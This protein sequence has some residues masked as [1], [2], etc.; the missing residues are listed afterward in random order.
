MAKILV[1]DDRQINRQFLVSLLK[2]GRH[3]LLEASDGEEALTIAREVKPDLIITD[4]LMPRMDGYELVRRLKSDQTLVNTP[5]IFYTAHYR[6][7]EAK[8]IAISCGVKHVITKPSEPEI[9]LKTV[10]EILNSPLSPSLASM[11]VAFEAGSMIVIA[12]KLLEKTTELKATGMKFASLIEFGMEMASN[13]NLVDLHKRFCHAAQDIIGVKHAAIGI[14]DKDGHTLT[15]VY[16]IGM[17]TE[18]AANFFFPQSNNRIFDMLLNK[19]KACRI[20]DLSGDPSAVGLPLEHP[21]VFSF[22]GVP[23]VAHTKVFGWL[24][25]SNKLGAEEFSEEDERLAGTLGA[26][27][28]LAY[29][30]ALLNDETQRRSA[31]LVN[32]IAER[33]RVEK[34]LRDSNERYRL[35]FESNP[36]PMWA[37]DRETLAFLTVNDSAVQR[38]GYSREEFLSMTIKDIRPPDDVNTLLASLPN[39]TTKSHVVGEW[40]HRK[41]DRTIINVEII[42]HDFILAGRQARLIIS[43]DITE[44]KQAEEMRLRRTNQTALRTDVVSAI[45]KFRTLRDIL[46]QCAEAIVQNLDAAFARIWTLNK[47]ENVLELQSSAGMYTHIDGDHGRVPVGKFKIGLIAQERVPHLSNDVVN[48]PRV[49][50]KEW[51]KQEKM[52]AFAG[53]PL[54]VED[55]LVGVMALFARKLLRDDTLDTLASVADIIAESIERKRAEE[56]LMQERT[57]LAHRVEERTA[58]LSLANAQLARA[59]RHKD[60]FLASMS[61]ELRTPLNAIL[62]LSE[63]LQEEIYGMLNEKQHKSLRTIEESGRHLLTLINDILDLSKI[64]AGRMELNIGPISIEPICQACLRI[65]KETANRKRIKVAPTFEINTKTV[66]ADERRLKQILVNL[67]SNAVKFTSEGGTVGLEVTEDAE[68]QIVRFT[69]WDTGI[70]ISK[71]NL[72]LL[73]KPFVQLDS[74]LSR[75]HA[76]TGLGLA[77]VSRMVDMLGGSILVESEVGKGSRFTV[78]LPSQD[79]HP[80]MSIDELRLIEPHVNGGISIQRALIIEDIFEHADQISRYLSE[81]GAKVDVHSQGNGVVDKV[82]Q[83]HHDLIILDIILPD[84]TGWDVLAQLKAEPQTRDIPVLLISVM[85]ERERGLALGA[86]EYLTKPISR[87]QIYSVLRKILPS[88]MECIIDKPVVENDTLS[89]ARYILLA[90]DNETNIRFISEYLAAKGYRTAVARNGNEVIERAG[91]ERP[92]L[93]LMDIQMPVMDGLEATCRIRANADLKNIPIIALTAL[94][95]NGDREQCL[96]AGANDYMSKPVNLKELIKK[97]EAQLENKPG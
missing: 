91:E 10:S 21:P 86:D 18:K 74:S 64:E 69:V 23:L 46:Q 79:F 71:E 44:R 5:V 78:L 7:R 13:Q 67:L 3:V 11:P 73:F 92:D 17:K 96:S 56:A 37:Y 65:I 93:I 41:K 81:L 87:Q 34:E 35:L 97:I 25:L 66:Q 83:L 29:E 51:A 57:L 47:E 43:S 26:Q 30:N 58:E 2:Y 52:V 61:H 16:F 49:G 22:L 50:N 88:K 53:Y 48:D 33:E 40:R 62:G 24:F 54:I 55:R 42:A 8:E 63:A 59:S 19:H 85:D 84:L 75:Q 20:N 77:L 14:L 76:G 15:A 28:A 27:M 9:I 31:E 6:E 80:K 68:Q 1:V 4:I 89:P 12:E 45:A 94:A 38:Y 70:G 39:L 72:P 82:L 60:D 32:E 90:E 36:Q 95:M